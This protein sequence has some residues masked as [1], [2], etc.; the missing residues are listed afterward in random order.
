MG[1]I[2]SLTM[3]YVVYWVLPVI[4]VGNVVVGLYLAYKFIIE[5]VR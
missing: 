2:I 4:V 1:I 3:L 5:L